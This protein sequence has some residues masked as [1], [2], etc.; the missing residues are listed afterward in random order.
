MYLVCRGSE[1]GSIAAG[2]FGLGDE[3]KECLEEGALGTGQAEEGIRTRAEH[4][5]ELESRPTGSLQPL[6]L[7]S[8]GE[9]LVIWLLVFV[10]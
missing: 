5:P 9:D 3:T 6:S 10:C 7:A 2:I 8:L 4:W 1:A